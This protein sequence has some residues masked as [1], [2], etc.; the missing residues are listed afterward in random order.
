MVMPVRQI[1]LTDEELF[2]RLFNA[3]SRDQ[4][5]RPLISVR[6]VAHREGD[7]EATAWIRKTLGWD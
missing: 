6:I 1:N 7:E 2:E 5:A 4:F 3:M